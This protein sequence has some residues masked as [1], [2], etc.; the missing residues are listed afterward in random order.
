M[1]KR[2]V[3]V[4]LSMAISLS[5]T[6][7]SFA[8]QWRQSEVNWGWWYQNDDGTYPVNQWVWIDG[9]NDGIAE[10]Y[11]FDSNGYCLQDTTTPDGYTV[12][13]SGAWTVNGAIQTQAVAAQT[14]EIQGTATDTQME[15]VQAI[16]P[17]AVDA[18]GYMN[19][20]PEGLNL[21][22]SQSVTYDNC[23]S[24]WVENPRM[25]ED[26]VK[27]MLNENHFPS[28]TEEQ[29]LGMIKGVLT[30]YPHNPAET[31]PY[32]DWEW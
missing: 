22:E 17:K 26:Y 24:Y 11:Y 4:G 32:E 27:E 13:A 19:Y 5:A 3:T 18:G 30:K 20:S 31:I 8:G 7:I 28:L 10:S 25:S 16:M 6:F 12:N 9:N 21:D 1:K 29:R 23:V 14:T 2:V 15:H